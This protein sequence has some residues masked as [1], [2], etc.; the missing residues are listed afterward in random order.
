METKSNLNT[1]GEMHKAMMKELELI[2]T[3]NYFYDGKDD[4]LWGRHQ[5]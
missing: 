5:R 2:F 3:K 4:D 1:W